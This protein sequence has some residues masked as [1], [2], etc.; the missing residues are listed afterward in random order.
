M[1]AVAALLMRGRFHAIT[2]AAVCGAASLMLPP[3]TYIS[4]AI[5]ALSTLKQGYREGLLVVL[6]ALVLSAVFSTVMP[7]VGSPMPAVAFT[8]VSPTVKRWKVLSSSI[9]SGGPA[10]TR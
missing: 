2:A 3:L 10:T 1:R 9:K 4:G 8:V 6:G 5:V 7:E